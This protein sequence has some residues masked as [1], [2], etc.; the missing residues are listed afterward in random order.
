M[1]SRGGGCGASLGRVIVQEGCED[2]ED[3]EDYEDYEGWER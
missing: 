3:S 2:S 1:P